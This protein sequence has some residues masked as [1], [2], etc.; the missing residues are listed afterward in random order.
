M[1]KCT[2]R[3]GSWYRW[4]ATRACVVALAIAALPQCQANRLVI[5]AAPQPS[6]TDKPIVF[7]SGL[8][9][10][11]TLTN[12]IEAEDYNSTSAP[13][14]VTTSYDPV[15]GGQVI[16]ATQPNTSVAYTIVAATA[17]TYALGLRLSAPDQNA[18][19]ALQVGDTNVGTSPPIGSTGANSVFIDYVVRN[20]SLAQGPQTLWVSLNNDGLLLDW[21]DVTGNDQPTV[22]YPAQVFWSNMDESAIAAAPS[23]WSFVAAHLDGL[24]WGNNNL[25]QLQV[26]A[27]ALSP[28]AQIAL[29]TGGLGAFTGALPATWAS[30]VAT[31]INQAINTVQ[32]GAQVLVRQIH[33]NQDPTAPL[34]SLACATPSDSNAQ[35]GNTFADSLAAVANAVHLANPNVEMG[36]FLGTPV[37]TT[38]KY[39][40]AFSGPGIAFSPLEDTSNQP[41]TVNGQPVSFFFDTYPILS[42]Y[43]ATAPTA[44]SGYITDSPGEYFDAGGTAY[45]AKLFAYERWLHGI[46]KAHTLITDRYNCSSS[47][48]AAADACYYQAI[49]NYLHAY[50]GGGGRADTYL[51]FQLHNGPADTVPETMPN[52]FANTVM[53]AIKYLKGP[54]EQ[55]DLSLQSNNG[56]ALGVGTYQSTPDANQTQAMNINPG[57]QQNVTIIMRNAGDVAAM[58]VLRAV[59]QGFG[60]NIV[61]TLQVDATD[62]TYEVLRGSG[63]VWTGLLAAGASATCNLNIAVPAGAPLTKTSLTLQALWNPQDPNGTVRDAVAVSI[64][65]G[66]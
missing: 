39:M 46:G 53:D 42:R 47:T 57:T 64:T 8:P 45:Q 21:I 44:T 48:D 9:A 62:V 17:G 38:W 59:V 52:T 30:D 20:V 7:V 56:A 40:P 32:N 66:N 23:Q 15:P 26:A 13:L 25:A 34:Q 4:L 5:A 18:T 16:A 35:L 41:V 49:M 14:S 29:S 12:R 2:A 43:F 3:C 60:T 11:P 33:V 36:V 6:S 19:L 63:H 27:A 22:A 24:E 37:A 55:L 58:P 50:Q 31:Q 10:G 51:I 61:P 65:S 54:G 28:M 1:R